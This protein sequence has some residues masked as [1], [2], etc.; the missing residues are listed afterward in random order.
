MSWSSPCWKRLTRCRSSSPNP[1]LP[2]NLVVLVLTG[3]TF[4]A[5]RR[6]SAWDL[7]RTRATNREMS[8][9]RTLFQF[10]R[11][12]CTN[13][14]ALMAEDLAVRHQ[15]A[16]LHRSVKRPKL[17]KRDRLFWVWLSRHWSAWPSALP[18]VQPETVVRWH[19]RGFRLYRRWKSRR[20]RRGRPQVAREI[21]DLI[22]RMSC[23]N[24]TLGVP[25]ILSELLLLGHSVAESTVARH[26]TLAPQAALAIAVCRAADRVYP[27][28]MSGPHERV[29]RRAS[30]AHSGRVLWLL[31]RSPGAFIVGS[32]L[33]DSS[34]R[35][36]AGGERGGRAQL[37]P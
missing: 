34:A 36:P 3:L 4:L 37:E 27:P 6:A 7:T 32:Q 13:R 31:S 15:L 14:A 19:G 26:M 18:L 10:L 23:K 21:R 25:W 1:V 20:R 5:S 30:A 8:I 35:L 22:R 28:G 29:W 33:A 11:D 24:P 2:E 9:F 16:V 12:L 17:R